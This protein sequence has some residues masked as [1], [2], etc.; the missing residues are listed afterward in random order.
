[1]AFAAG[2]RLAQALGNTDRMLIL[3][4]IFLAVGW[5]I[6]GLVLTFVGFALRE[7]SRSAWVQRIVF[8]AF[9]ALVLSPVL[10]PLGLTAALPMPLGAMLLFVR[11][12]EDI[13]YFVHLWYFVLPSMLITGFACWCIARRLFPNYSFKRTADVGLR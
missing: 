12:L 7:L 11:S 4:A 6:G 1:M 13:L 8:A 2:G 9:G 5:F 10:F 3:S